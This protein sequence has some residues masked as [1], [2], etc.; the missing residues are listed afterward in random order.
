MEKNDVVKK[1]KGMNRYWIVQGNITCYAVFRLF[2][3]LYVMGYFSGRAS[4][5]SELV[6]YES[7]IKMKDCRR[8]LVALPMG[9]INRA[10]RS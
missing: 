4:S 3:S 10:R 2:A 7:A 1:A 8:I 5:E 6:D 9:D